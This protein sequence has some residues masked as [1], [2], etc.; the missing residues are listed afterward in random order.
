MTKL[1]DALEMK[2]PLT[3]ASTI[4][5]KNLNMNQH[6]NKH[7]TS[8]SMTLFAQN[9]TEHGNCMSVVKAFETLHCAS[10][11]KERCLIIKEKLKNTIKA[12]CE[13]KSDAAAH[14]AVVL[15]DHHWTNQEWDDVCCLLAE[16]DSD[17]IAANPVLVSTPTACK[18]EMKDDPDSPGWWEAST[19]F[20]SEQFWTVKD[21]EIKDLI[22]KKT[23]PATPGNMPLELG[24][25]VTHRTRAFKK[26]RLPNGICR[27]HK[28][29]FC[30]HGDLQK[31]SNKKM[32]EAVDTHCIF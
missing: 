14:L 11:M 5:L 15:E 1:E 6:Q 30:V 21:K 7:E 24:K 12:D 25:Q 27:K 20:G 28:A 8:Q 26:R 4:L 32:L 2:S 18:S 10:W 13:W 9:I 29:R 19:G 3:S 17:H 22:K 23:W 16:L 31:I